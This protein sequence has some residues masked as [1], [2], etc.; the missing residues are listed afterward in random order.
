MSRL[1]RL[2]SLLILGAVRS[3]PQEAFGTWKGLD[4]RGKAVVL[5]IE[6]HARG[7]VVTV[8]RILPSG[9][10]ATTSLILSL[11][12]EPREF[13]GERCAGT[14]TSKRLDDRT[15]EIRFQCQDGRTVH[16]VR[17]VSRKLVVEFSDQPH[18]SRPVA[19]RLIFEKQ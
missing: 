16:I 15:I 19:W 5:R 18:G 9:T 2:L 6:P 13:R 10:A 11:N 17:R 12:G 4:R 8:D 7:E 3:W 1:F 14:Q